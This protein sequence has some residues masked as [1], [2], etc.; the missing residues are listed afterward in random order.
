MDVGGAEQ[1]AINIASS[2][3]CDMD[4]HIVEVMRGNSEYTKRII[5][6]FET[7]GIK[8]HRALLPVLFHWHYLCERI[9]ALIFPLRMLFLWIKYHPDIIHSHT[10]IADM[11]LWWTIHVF[12]FI[13]VRI[14][15]TIHNT[16]LWAGMNIIG[17][18]VERFMQRHKANIAIS[19]NVQEAYSKIYGTIPPI[20]YNGVTATKQIHYDKIV[21]GKINIC[22]AGRLEEQKGISTLRDII[23]LLKNDSRYHFHIFGSGRLQ[24][25]IDNLKGLQNVSINTPM[26]GIAAC[27]QSFDYLIMPSIHEGLSIL[28][29]EASFNELPVMINHCDGL[30]DTLPENWPLVVDN[31]DLKQWMNLFDNILPHIDRNTLIRQASEYANSHFSIN[32]MQFE[33]ETF[34]RSLIH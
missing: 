1:V 31:N 30:T 8:Y 10:E 4:Y 23:T 27:L 3:S 28:A 32:K 15:R 13:D 11:A 5:A 17:P 6:E 20:I 18:Q 2:K 22:F 29:L 21:N 33:Y 26:H 7:K 12:Q 34:Y 19:A 16:K 14:V 24:G 9:L 25:L